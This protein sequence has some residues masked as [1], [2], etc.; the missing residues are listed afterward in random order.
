MVEWLGF[1]WQAAAKYSNYV[2][3]GNYPVVHT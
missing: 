3:R 2:G 1:K